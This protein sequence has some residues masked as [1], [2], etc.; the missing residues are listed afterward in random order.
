MFFEKCIVGVNQ[1]CFKGK[2]A[3]YYAIDGEF[4]ENVDVVSFLL[5]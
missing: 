5:E 1:K 2:T 4:G 3:L